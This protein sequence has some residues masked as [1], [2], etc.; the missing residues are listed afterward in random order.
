M[1]STVNVTVKNVSAAVSSE[2]FLERIR[3]LRARE[4]REHLVPMREVLR[5]AAVSS[6]SAHDCE[7]VALADQLDVP[8]VTADRAIVR[9]AGG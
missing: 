8:L 2:E 7:F 3:A 9:A 6:C 1:G 5:L 4:G